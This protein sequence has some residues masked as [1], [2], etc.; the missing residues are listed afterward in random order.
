MMKDTSVQEGLSVKFTS[1]IAPVNPR[2]DRDLNKAVLALSHRRYNLGDSDTGYN[3]R[4]Y[5]GWSGM[6]ADLEA[7]EK[8]LV[9]APVYMLDHGGLVISTKPFSC[10]MDSGQ[11]GWAFVPA[12][13]G[14]TAEQAQY[15]LDSELKLYGAYISGDLYDLTIEAP[16]SG[17]I[18]LEEFSMTREQAELAVQDFL[19]ARRRGAV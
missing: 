16:L 17:E 6:K 5:H 11:V 1:S 7:K 4:D 3:T 9:I 2:S 18:L 13:S 10:A 15:A 19:A 8:P 14:L 12:S